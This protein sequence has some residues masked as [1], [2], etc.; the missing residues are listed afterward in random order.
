MVF[1]LGSQLIFGQDKNLRPEL[2]ELKLQVEIEVFNKLNN[3]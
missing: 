3:K 1:R 2:E